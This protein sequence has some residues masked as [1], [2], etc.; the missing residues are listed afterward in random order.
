MRGVWVHGTFS[1]IGELYIGQPVHVLGLLD[2]LGRTY[3]D[4]DE[5]RAIVLGSDG[6]VAGGADVLPRS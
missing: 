2:N 4:F 1:N 5:E 6:M 3:S